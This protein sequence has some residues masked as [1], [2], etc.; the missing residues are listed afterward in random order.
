M[1]HPAYCTTLSADIIESYLIFFW[2]G[3][4]V[5]QRHGFPAPLR[6]TFHRWRLHV[7]VVTLLLQLVFVN[8]WLAIKNVK[9]ALLTFSFSILCAQAGWSQLSTEHQWPDAT[10]AL[11]P[12]ARNPPTRQCHVWLLPPLCRFSCHP[13][14]P[15]G[16]TPASYQVILMC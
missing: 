8:L 12:P 16:F 5:P 4:R 14:L 11:E 15:G 13:R 3:G 1:S 2:S 9:K 6:T 10:L 7:G